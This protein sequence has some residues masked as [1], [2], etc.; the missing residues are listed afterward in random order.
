MHMSHGNIKNLSIKIKIFYN[1]L[2]PVNIFRLILNHYFDTDL[3]TLE[4][5]SYF[6]TSDKYY[7][8]INANNHM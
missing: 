7:D 5:I 2:T 1:T 4:D 3:K 8:F 6:S